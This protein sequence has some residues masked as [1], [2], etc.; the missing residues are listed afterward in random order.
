[1][2]WAYRLTAAAEADLLQMYQYTAERWGVSQ[3]DI[4]QR[5]LHRHL[6]NTAENPSIGVAQAHVRR[7]VRKYQAESH[8]IYYRPKREQVEVLRVLHTRQDASRAFRR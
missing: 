3:A 2:S 5:D 4:Y 7:N 6:S 8:V 1:M